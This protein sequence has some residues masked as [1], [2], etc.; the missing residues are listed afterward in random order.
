MDYNY[1][2]NSIKNRG[3]TENSEPV[4]KREEEVVITTF[5]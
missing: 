3:K 2:S 4:T 1:K 5:R